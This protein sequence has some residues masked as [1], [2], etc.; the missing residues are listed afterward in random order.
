MIN[1]KWV[2]RKGVTILGKYCTT[3]T[4]NRVVVL[5]Y[6]SVHPTK[7]FASATPELF[8]SHLLWLKEYCEIIPFHQVFE[9]MHCGER[10]RPAVAIRGCC[11]TLSEGS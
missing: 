8:D 9:A 2:K 3:Q 11:K 5:C 10:A 6:H 4:Q 7:P 1:T